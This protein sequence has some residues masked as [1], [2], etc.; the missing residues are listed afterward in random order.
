MK[1]KPVAFEIEHDDHIFTA[2]FVKDNGWVV[3]RRH[4]TSPNIPPMMQLLTWDGW[5]N[6]LKAYDS[7]VRYL[8]DYELEHIDEFTGSI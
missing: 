8:T 4:N 7:E 5:V 2:H 1:W 6:S 3:R